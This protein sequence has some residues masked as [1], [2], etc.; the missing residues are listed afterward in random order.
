MWI[1]RTLSSIVILFLYINTHHDTVYR[2]ME[3]EEEEE[4]KEEELKESLSAWFAR[5]TR[6][7]C[8]SNHN[9]P[10][11]LP[12]ESALK[13]VYQ[14]LL[15]VTRKKE[16]KKET[17]QLKATLLKLLLLLSKCACFGLLTCCQNWA[18]RSGPCDLVVN[19]SKDSISLQQTSQHDRRLNVQHFQRCVQNLIKTPF[20]FTFWREIQI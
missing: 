7:C 2:V 5:S 17:T 11:W 14:S 20:F 18:R 16:G 4:E 12:C 9:R 15:F 19:Q 3:E 6:C 1:T 13:A 8:V 10:S